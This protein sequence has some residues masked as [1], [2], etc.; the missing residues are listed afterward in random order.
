MIGGSLGGAARLGRKRTTLLSKMER[1]GIS[2]IRRLEYWN[3]GVMSD[4][5][6][7]KPKTPVLSHSNHAYD[8]QAK[9]GRICIG[10][11]K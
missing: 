2:R 4:A 11:A 3:D 7:T 1:L 8:E 10:S 5:F 6:K 9:S